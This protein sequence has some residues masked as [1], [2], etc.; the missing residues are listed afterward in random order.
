MSFGSMS[1]RIYVQRKRKISTMDESRIDT[2]GMCVDNV[3]YKRRNYGLGCTYDSFVV[4]E[5]NNVRKSHHRVKAY[6]T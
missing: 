2:I 5:N 3:V 4:R 1:V 6:L